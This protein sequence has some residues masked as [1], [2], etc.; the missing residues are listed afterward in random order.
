[1]QGALN[2]IRIAREGNK[3]FL[4]TCGGF[5]HA[6]IEYARSVL[7]VAEADHAESNPSASFPLITPLSCS[8]VGAHGTIL[9]APGSKAEA[10]YGASKTDEEYH[11]NFGLNREQLPKLE[12]GG[13]RFSGFDTEGEP[14]IFELPDHTFFMGTLFQPELTA[15][16]GVTHPLV[17]EYVRA[18][19]ASLKC[20]GGQV[21]NL[22]H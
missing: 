13:L 2:G 6:L 9:L 12:S 17:T 7:K 3:P 21:G 11:C 15:L 14:R 20:S 10:A 16:K 19:V 22:P 1:M 4:G 18:T 8:L 5:Q